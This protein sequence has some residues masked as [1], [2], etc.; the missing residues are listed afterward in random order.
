MLTVLSRTAVV[1]A[2]LLRN[3][4]VCRIFSSSITLLPCSTSTLQIK[5]MYKRG[6][7]SC[8]R[9]DWLSIKFQAEKWIFIFNWLFIN[10]KDVYQEFFRIERLTSFALKHKT[11]H[12]RM[13]LFDLTIDMLNRISVTHVASSSVSFEKVVCDLKYEGLLKNLLKFACWQTNVFFP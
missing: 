7:C 13:T 5:W 3:D 8:S 9:A 6:V 11:F 10:D 4:K 2:I 1:L 12:F